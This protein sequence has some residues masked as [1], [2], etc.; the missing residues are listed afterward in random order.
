MYCIA[1]KSEQNRRLV[2]FVFVFVA[3]LSVPCD[4]QFYFSMFLFRLLIQSKTP[5]SKQRRHRWW[6]D[7]W[8]W[9]LSVEIVLIE[10]L[11]RTERMN[12]WIHYNLVSSWGWDLSN[13]DLCG[14]RF[15]HSNAW[16]MRTSSTAAR[17]ILASI[18]VATANSIVLSIYVQLWSCT[19]L[20]AIATCAM[21]SEI[22][23]TMQF[24]YYWNPFNRFDDFD[25][26]PMNRIC[27]GRCTAHTAPCDNCRR[28]QSHRLLV[29]MV[30][31]PANSMRYV[32]WVL[33]S[34]W[35]RALDGT[36]GMCVFSVYRWLTT[37]LQKYSKNRVQWS[38]KHQQQLL[39]A[40]ESDGW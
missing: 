31:I 4:A 37:N 10:I 21:L 16:E 32:T 40:S 12:E 8:P 3:R 26:I 20:C 2:A 38:I 39:F 27:C 5:S 13:R 19:R 6:C 11:R 34:N 15:I 18:V 29:L 14:I 23:Q 24:E 33:D 22:E 7:A 9:E 17:C 36:T 35:R 30:L 25:D 28:C 1:S